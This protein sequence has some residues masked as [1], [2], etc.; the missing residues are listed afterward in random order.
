MV[1]TVL[2]PGHTLTETMFDFCTLVL[3]T[4]AEGGPS[5]GLEFGWLGA[6]LGYVGD[7]V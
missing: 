3:T 2:M 6:R 1:S 4:G 5:S 7:A